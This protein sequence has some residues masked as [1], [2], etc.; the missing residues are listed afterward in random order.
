MREKIIFFLIVFIYWFVVFPI[1]FSSI[2]R[3]PEIKYNYS[4][5]HGGTGFAENCMDLD[6]TKY[7]MFEEYTIVVEEY[8]EVD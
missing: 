6:N 4:N 8:W 5:G 3:T 7:C 2:E 1:L